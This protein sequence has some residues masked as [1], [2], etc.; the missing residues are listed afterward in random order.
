MRERIQPIIPWITSA[1]LLTLLTLVLR[2]V[3][4][5]DIPPHL[6]YDEAGQ[7]LDAREILT[8]EFRAFFP[9]SMGKEPLYIYL[10]V[11][12]VAVGDT[13]PVAVRLSAALTG[14]LTVIA[15]VLAGRAL[16]PERPSIGWKVGLIAAALWASNYWPQSVNRLGFRVNTL[17]LVLTLATAMWA[18]WTR[19]PNRRN[20]FVFGFLAGLTLLTYLA[21]RITP[22]LWLALWLIALSP[23]QRRPLRSTLPA[24]ITGFA[25]GSGPLLIHF[26]LHPEDAV[27]RVATFPV[28]AKLQ[29]TSDIFGLYAHE[30]W[31]VMGGFFG[32]A[33]DPIPRHNLPGRPPFFPI[34]GILFAAGLCVGLYNATRG[35]GWQRWRAR[36]LILWW[37]LLLIPATLAAT[38]NPHFLRLFGAVPP[39]LLVAAWPLAELWARLTTRKYALGTL[40][41]LAFLLTELIRTGHAY[42]V[43]WAQH[44]DLYSW[45]QE[46]IWT[47]GEQVRQT[48]GAIGVVPLNPFYGNSYREYVLQYVFKDVPIF[49]MQVFE[50]KIEEWLDTHLGS[51]GEKPVI[52]TIWQK[53]EHVNADPKDILGFY[54]S[55]EGNLLQRQQFR[56]FQLATYRLGPHPQF[57]VAGNVVPVKA[58]FTQGVR[59]LQARWGVAYPNP[60]RSAQEA[61]AGTAVWA[62]L[63]WQLTKPLPDLKVTLD[64]VDGQGH[65]LASDERWLLD[66]DRWPTSRWQPGTIGRS[67]HIVTIPATTIP[68]TLFLES[69]VYEGKT[70]RNLR[71]IANTTHLGIRWAAVQVKPA[72][73]YPQ[74]AELSIQY[75]LNQDL[76]PALRLIGAATWPETVA[77][78]QPV[79]LRL[80]WEVRERLLRDVEVT[81]RLRGGPVIG[82]ARLP[83]SLPVGAVVHTDIDFTVPVQIPSNTYSVIATANGRPITL[84]PLR[85]QGRPRHFTPPPIEYPMTATFGSGIQ[86]LGVTRV[87]REDNTLRFTLV[88]QVAGAD[89]RPLKRFVHVLGPDRKPIAQEDIIPCAGECPAY[90]WVPQEILIDPVILHL[91]PNAIDKPYPIAVGWYDS[92]TLERLPALD[93]HGEPV[94]DNL[95]VLPIN[96][97]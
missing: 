42:F 29:R 51:A 16:W 27:N 66:S 47:I 3:A 75:P 25:L 81:F 32:W 53:G 79:S 87:Q 91:P 2:G 39:A 93:A 83:A 4:L 68:G 13:F 55:R 34:V 69:R 76:L 63:T 88:W 36:A 60:N 9:R 37:M 80:Y 40:A 17:P 33:G 82:Q 77:P 48:P 1:I 64:L 96:T 31:A 11:P 97:P 20:A 65:R 15:L 94:A 41:I 95:V 70:L 89:P 22:I 54:L 46:D 71:P 74:A 43:E 49:Q 61:I 44:T 5:N 6:Y 59:L 73:T 62:V 7:G 28:W 86:L 45:F 67:Y 78:G 38:D 10:T 12:F 92:I 72:S 52:V 35:R 23:E 18:V 21:A 8:G 30:I 14:T 57:K 26:A 19:R 24:V 50:D 84:G 90:S 85:V 58:S 56:R